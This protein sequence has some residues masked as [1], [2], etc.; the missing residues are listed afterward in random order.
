[1]PLA[2][3]EQLEKAASFALERQKPNGGFGATPTLPATI[4]DTYH[5]LKILHCIGTYCN[6][7]RV[8]QYGLNKHL[9]FLRHFTKEPRNLSAKT[10]FQLV[11]CF[12]KCGGIQEAKNL[13][14]KWLRFAHCN[15]REDYYYLFRT[16]ELLQMAKSGPICRENF[17]A[18]DG[19]LFNRWMAIFLD[20]QC[21]TGLIDKEMA[22]DWIKRCQ[23]Y[24]G[25]FGFLPGSTSY[26]ENSHYALVAL[27]KLG[28][29]LGNKSF[30]AVD[31][32]LSCQSEPGG[33]SRKANAAPFLDATWHGTSSLI[34]LSKH[35]KFVQITTS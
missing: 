8:I 32:V 13:I 31:F 2:F 4:E 15:S 6:R 3:C 5:G 29:G 17:I 25:G 10:I 22:S 26:L 35:E 30:E 11:W 7:D 28:K 20:L 24:D 12:T 1:M 19:I 27:F 33:F 23:N 16:Y 18:F 34:L 14:H 21:K 9:E